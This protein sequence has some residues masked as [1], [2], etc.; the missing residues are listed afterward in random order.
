MITPAN[1]GVMSAADFVAGFMYG[2]TGQNHL[3]EIEACYT[4]GEL[5]VNEIETGIADF[6]KGGWDNITQGILQLGLVGLQI[7][8]AL[9]TCE[10][11]DEDVAA[12]KEWGSIFKN[13]T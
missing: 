12:I 13:P 4:G 6:K 3:T 1:V 10:N 2:M 11:M 9:H 7:P 8:Q 5:M